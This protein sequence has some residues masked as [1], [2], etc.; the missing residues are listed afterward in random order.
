M[1]FLDSGKGGVPY[2]MAYREHDQSQELV[3]VADTATF[4]YGVKE[5]SELC[6]SLRTTIERVID[7]FDPRLIVL[8]C[9][10][11]S[12][13]ALKW[14]R[15][16]ISTPLV[17][18]VPA[19]KPASTQTTAGRI[20]LLVTERTATGD[21]LHDL[22]GQFA[23]DRIVIT[24]VAGRIVK[25]VETHATS[26]SLSSSPVIDKLI[27]EVLD[28]FASAN[29]DTLV[30]GCTHFLYIADLLR[31]HTTTTT[32]PLTIIDSRAGVTARIRQLL[33]ASASASASS[34]PAPSTAVA[35]PPFCY[36]TTIPPISQSLQQLLVNCNIRY[37]GML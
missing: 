25:Y 15:Q 3:Y 28:E 36:T 12:V 13:T 34:P 29:V 24:V 27:R 17:G 35:A 19:V 18:V 22:I 30:L 8:A 21:Y 5:S 7:R 4:P 10:T 2:L 33:S 37:D 16:H 9:N 6:H 1:V 32:T 14:L 23:A 31:A 20:G 11:A 26:T